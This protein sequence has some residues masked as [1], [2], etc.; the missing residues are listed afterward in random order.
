MTEQ[1]NASIPSLV[2]YFVLALGENRAR[3]LFTVPTSLAESLTENP[4]MCRDACFTLMI[5]TVSQRARDIGNNGT[6]NNDTI[7]TTFISTDFYSP[8]PE[9]TAEAIAQ[10]LSN[11]ITEPAAPTA[12][13]LGL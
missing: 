6:V 3:A 4:V 5:D 7:A 2:P 12:S 11:R 13:M 8:D 9:G 10:R 1:D